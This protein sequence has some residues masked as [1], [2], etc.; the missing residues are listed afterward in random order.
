MFPH[1]QLVPFCNP[2]YLKFSN[3]QRAMHSSL[4]LAEITECNPERRSPEKSTQSP[5]QLTRRFRQWQ[6]SFFPFE[7]CPQRPG[8]DPADKLNVPVRCSKSTLFEKSTQTP[9]FSHWLVQPLS[10]QFPEDEAFHQKLLLCFL[11]ITSV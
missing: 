2:A 3:W 1:Q 8:F 10:V 4:V 11:S 7:L 9:W 6:Q 5:F